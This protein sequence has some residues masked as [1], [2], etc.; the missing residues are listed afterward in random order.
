METMGKTTI[1]IVEDESIVAADLT[2]KL[3]RL[4]YEVVGT[5][6]QGEEAVAMACRL[7]PQ[8]VLMDIWLEGP[9]DGIHAAEAIRG[10]YDVPVIYLTAHSDPIALARAKLT[11]PFGYLLKP[12]E[13]RELATQIEMAIF[14]H[15]ADR[16]TAKLARLYA[17][18]SRVNEAI[19]RTHDAEMLCSAVCRI[20]TEQ[21]DF[22]LAWIGQVREQQVVSLAACGP[23]AGYVREIRVELQGV[24]GGGPTGT[25]IRE[26]RAVVDNDYATTRQ[27][28]PGAN[29]PCATVSAFGRRSTPPSGRRSAIDHLCS[30]CQRL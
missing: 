16:R 11:G 13:E 15:Q 19:V 7:R 5:A 22:A 17:M 12:F 25:C 8:L 3:G 28:S 29:R 2:G 26:N 10:E 24:L 4:G 14:R 27:R 20:V 9:M 1:L 18:L 6:A 23:A 30:R 21:G